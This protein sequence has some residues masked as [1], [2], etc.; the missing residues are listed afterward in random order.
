MDIRWTYMVNW[1]ARRAHKIPDI[2]FT[3]RTV[4]KMRT[5]NG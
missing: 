3:A 1:L 5:S 2:T 4:H